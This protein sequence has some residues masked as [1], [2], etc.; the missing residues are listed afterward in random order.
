[1]ET[2]I[3]S[4]KHQEKYSISYIQWVEFDFQLTVYWTILCIIFEA[5]IASYFCSLMAELLK[6]LSVVMGIVI[7]K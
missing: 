7:F 4:M 5:T 2:R 6:D 3:T 1:M